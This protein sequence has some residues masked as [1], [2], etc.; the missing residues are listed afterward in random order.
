MSTQFVGWCSK[1][2][3]EPILHVITLDD[4][5]TDDENNPDD[6][7]MPEKFRDKIKAKHL[8]ERKQLEE[9]RE[10]DR[11]DGK[12][13]K[14][15][16]DLVVTTTT[17]SDWAL[18]A[19][20]GMVQ[21]AEQEGKNFKTTHYDTCLWQVKLTHPAKCLLTSKLRRCMYAS[22][23]HTMTIIRQDKESRDFRRM[24]LNDSNPFCRTPVSQLILINEVS[25]EMI[26]ACSPNGVV[27]IWDPY[28]FP[29]SDDYANPAE[30]VS[31][32]F[33]LESQMT[34]SSQT[35]RCLFE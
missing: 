2:F 8:I 31:A 10:K 24:D 32:S 16:E 14:N 18:H 33:P 6:D 29:F 35:N 3:V 23:G 22:D 12:K 9:K 17:I 5:N 7:M 15:Q 1:V 21:S 20:E 30:L 25:R 4:V 34:L 13:E 11:K 19:M 26:I 28:F 27:R